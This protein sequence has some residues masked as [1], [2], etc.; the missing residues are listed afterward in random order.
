[1]LSTKPLLSKLI[2][3]LAPAALVS[4]FGIVLLSSLAKP[5]FVPPPVV[6]P[7]LPTLKTEAVFTP[8]PRAAE[9]EPVQL[10]EQPALPIPAPRPAAKPRPQP[11]KL[12]AIE[13]PTP[14]PQQIATAP[15]PAAAPVAVPPP[16]APASNRTVMARLRDATTSVTS[17][18]GRAYSRVA[19]WFAHEEPPRPPAEVPGADFNATM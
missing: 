12:A 15:V 11:H 4:A 17:I 14:R 7:A 13:L 3:Q 9:P 6:A 19:G 5:A 2:F 1:M 16:P 18:P 8:M 10:A